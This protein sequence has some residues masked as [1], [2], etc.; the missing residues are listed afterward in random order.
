MKILTNVI[1]YQLIWFFSVLGGN[2]GASG[3]I[4]LLLIHLLF[5]LKKRAD[6]LMMGFL[7]FTG[8]LVDGT[9]HQVGFITFAET[10]FPIPFWLMV[11]WLGLAITPHHSLAWLQNRPLLSMLFGALGGPAAYW[12]GVRLGAATFTWTLFPSLCT[13]SIIWVF[14]WPAVMYL[15]VVSKQKFSGDPVDK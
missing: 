3:G 6:L 1:I 5:S 14:L 8:L 2:T 4:V 7:L 13:L 15:S 9:L 10:G 11:I 12:A